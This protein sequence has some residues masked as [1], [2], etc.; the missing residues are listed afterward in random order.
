[1]NKRVHIVVNTTTEADLSRTAELNGVEHLVV[2]IIMLVEGVH[3]PSNAG[4][5]E[6]ALAE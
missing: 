2:P 6:L 5:G 4:R 1:M 3:N